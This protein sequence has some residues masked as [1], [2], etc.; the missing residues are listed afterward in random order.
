MP[1]PPIRFR[2]SL[3]ETRYIAQIGIS[4]NDPRVYILLLST[5]PG[6]FK[7]SGLSGQPLGVMFLRPERRRNETLKNSQRGRAL[8]H[9]M[10]FSIRAFYSAKLPLCFSMN[11]VSRLTRMRFTVSFASVTWTGKDK[12]SRVKTNLISWKFSISSGLVTR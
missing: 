3:L 8:V 4:R 12:T 7:A 11:L 2:L 9:E 10:L 5:R 1:S 6:I